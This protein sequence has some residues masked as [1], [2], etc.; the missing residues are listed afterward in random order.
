[1]DRVTAGDY[2]AYDAGTWS[3]DSQSGTGWTSSTA[4]PT[5]QASFGGY[6]AGTN[7]GTSV[8]GNT[9]GWRVLNKTGS[10][11]TG[12]VTLIS[13]GS[14]ALGYYASNSSTNQTNM[15]NALNN[16][17]SDNFLNTSFATSARN[18]NTNDWSQMNTAKVPTTGANY[19]MATA[20]NATRYNAA[21]SSYTGYLSRY[22]YYRNSSGT[23]VNSGSWS[24]YGYGTYY[25]SYSTSTTYY[26]LYAV[27]PTSA[28]W[29]NTF[30]YQGLRN[31]NGYDYSS[32]NYRQYYYYYVSS[33][34]SNGPSGTYYYRGNT[35][36][37]LYGVGNTT[38]SGNY[39]KAY[40]VRP[41][42]VLKAGVKTENA[43]DDNYLEQSCWALYE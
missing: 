3:A 32:G 16:F 34:Y 29:D 31:Y 5:T 26:L 11:A 12:T 17:A 35:S 39:N 28:T 43:A 33:S 40:G 4:T 27:H 41:I 42:V 22:Y 19:W 24:N 38:A 9:S 25:S 37:Q 18:A 21:G 23:V 20:I 15:I 8:S 6:T 36:S 14:P 1:M 2:V 13:A 30:T 7:K 10:G